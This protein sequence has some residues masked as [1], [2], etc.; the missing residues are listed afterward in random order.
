MSFGDSFCAD[1]GVLIAGGWVVSFSD[2]P[3]PRDPAHPSHLVAVS[4]YHDTHSPVCR[5]HTGSSL[6]ALADVLRLCVLEQERAERIDREEWL[7]GASVPC[8][9]ARK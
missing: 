7:N 9:P 3:P 8:G 2:V 4:V 1:L 6:A 5:S